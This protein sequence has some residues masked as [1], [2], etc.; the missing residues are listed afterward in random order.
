[1]TKE[2]LFRH[3]SRKEI[4]YT[5]QRKTNFLFPLGR[6]KSNFGLEGR[7]VRLP[8]TR[9]HTI[10]PYEDMAGLKIRLKHLSS[11]WGVVHISSDFVG[12]KRESFRLV[13]HHRILR[14]FA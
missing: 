2:F 4:S 1:M 14:Y 7:V 13:I 10:P 8:H 3:R 6:L 9:N 12:A 11:F 5:L